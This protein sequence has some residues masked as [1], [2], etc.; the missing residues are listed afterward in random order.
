MKPDLLE[1]IASYGDLVQIAPEPLSWAARLNIP[2]SR[3]TL[4]M[5]EFGLPVLSLR[6]FTHSWNQRI[7]EEFRGLV[8]GHAGGQQ[9]VRT[10]E[11]KYEKKQFN[12]GKPTK[13]RKCRS[14]SPSPHRFAIIRS[15]IRGKPKVL[16]FIQ[17]QANN[18]GHSGAFAFLATCSS[19][20]VTTP[21][22]ST[23]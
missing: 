1:L 2:S 23:C 20:F 15:L 11:N 21:L 17:G 19:V 13:H 10:V 9:L 16:P 4:I 22:D 14:I 5:D 18:L 12:T 6:T 7:S 3:L 8:R